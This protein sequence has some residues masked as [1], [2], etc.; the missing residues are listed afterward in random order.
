MTAA[1]TLKFERNSVIPIDPRTKI[2]LTLTVSTITMAGGTGGIM[3]II[4]PCLVALPIILLLLSKRFKA[5]ARFSITYIILYTLELLVIPMLTGV[6]NFILNAASGI[7]THMLPGFVMGYYLISTT[8]VS[9]FVAAMERIHVPQKVVIPLS[10]VF[11]FF[12]TEKEEY[13]AIRDA[14]KMRGI[15]TFRSPMKMLEYRV[16]P[17]MMSIAKIGEELSAAALT[18]GLGAPEKRTNICNIG[19][20]LLDIVFGIIS[21]LGWIGFFIK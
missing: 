9:E 6:W 2:F 21:I 16:V 3:N 1:T 18:R 7:Y 4:R 11:R 15:T 10:V 5:A 13:A 19:F 20:G 8:T 17:L 14:M 12:P